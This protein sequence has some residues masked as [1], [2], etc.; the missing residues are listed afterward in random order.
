MRWGAI[1]GG[2]VGTLFWSAAISAAAGWGEGNSSVG[3]FLNGLFWGLVTGVLA[4]ALV[5]GMI[6]DEHHEWRE[7]CPHPP[8]EPVNNQP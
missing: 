4:G 6:G 1:L 8:L 7:A 5:G 3:I 2:V